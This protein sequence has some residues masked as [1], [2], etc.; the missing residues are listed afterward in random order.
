MYPRSVEVNTV[1]LR[2]V[3]PGAAGDS[4][5]VQGS[6]GSNAGDGPTS[7]HPAV[8]YAA[9]VG[10]TGRPL[11]WW[12]MMLVLLVFLMW[13]SRKLGTNDGDFANIRLSAY[14]VLTIGLAS[15]IGISFFKMVF[16]KVPVPGLTS[17]VLAV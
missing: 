7:G 9:A 17:L 8:D 11:N 3:Y 10:M 6:A 2:N 14:N 5:G 4:L 16:T 15:I 1:N 12:V 13:G